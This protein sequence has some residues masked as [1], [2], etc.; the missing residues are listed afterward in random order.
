MKNKNGQ[1]PRKI[2]SSLEE[3]SRKLGS[4]FTL[5]SKTKVRAWK[6]YLIVFFVAGIAAALVLS[7]G[8]G[9]Q[10]KSSAKSTRAEE[11]A[12][13]KK[14][15]KEKGAKWKAADNPIFQLSDEERKKLAN[16][17]VD[18]EMKAKSYTEDPNP[19]A[20]VT[21]TP[22][23]LDWRNN[24]G[25]FVTPV[26]NQGGCGSCWAFAVTAALESNQLIAQ[27]KPGI[28]LDLSEQV[29]VSCSGAGSCSGGYP[30]LASLFARDTGLPLESCYSYTGTNGSCSN[31]CA[32]WQENTYKFGRYF[33][34]PKTVED[35]K[36]AL[37]TYGPLSTVFDVY[38]D[39]FSYRTGV[40]SYTSGSYVGGHAVIIIGY[41]DPGQ[42][43]IAKNSWGSGWGEGGYFRIAYSELNSI[44]GF[45]QG[46]LAY[47]NTPP[48]IQS[49]TVVSPNGGENW[50][51][52][53]LLSRSINWNY[54]GD[55]DA[56][57]KIELL[58]GGNVASVISSSK[59]V[60]ARSLNWSIPADLVPGS[61][62]KIR[63]TSIGNNNVSDTSDG[64]FTIT[65][66]IPPSLSLTSPNGGEIW[67]A[68]DSVSISWKLTGNPGSYLKIEL[69]KG[70]IVA[71][72]ISE[73]A[74]TANGSFGWVVPKD[75]EPGQDYQIRITSN[76]N[77][78]MTDTSE[79]YFSVI[80]FTPPGR[81]KKKSR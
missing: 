81:D 46:T 43:F 70:G 25:N 68:G 57:I 67:K 30:T 33:S 37:L 26:R 75:L 24:G 38:Q 7:A 52:G 58:K 65:E 17:K 79:G 42:Y 63:I 28:N 71:R 9:I 55:S 66:P 47:S 59:N 29:M 10:I 40:Y 74:S 11:L 20:Q 64:N 50:E 78:S 44:V 23:S 22:A 73:S 31:A 4:S 13:I 56:S 21:V 14:A 19:P 5:V 62:Y 60:S 34:V 16:A 36:T 69:L 35:I 8:T 12:Q 6:A 77:T 80:K 3:L 1:K 49:L 18:S 15:I 39:F 45:G 27:N 61:D 48:Q 76:T 72:T 54:T 51:A 2:D 53:S 41:D 32:N